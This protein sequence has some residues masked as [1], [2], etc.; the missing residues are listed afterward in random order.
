[1]IYQCALP[2]TAISE[3]KLDLRNDIRI[4]SSMLWS[5]MSTDQ[6]AIYKNY[7]DFLYVCISEVCHS[8]AVDLGMMK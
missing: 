2:L 1:M 6:K 8:L 4:S 7:N 5:R 3:L